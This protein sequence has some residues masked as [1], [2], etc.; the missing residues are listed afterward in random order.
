MGSELS[1]KGGGGG[2]GGG[3]LQVSV[4]FGRGAGRVWGSGR[5]SKPV[6]T[7]WAGSMWAG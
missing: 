3:G 5:G 7:R 2:G 4:G 1:P 6:A